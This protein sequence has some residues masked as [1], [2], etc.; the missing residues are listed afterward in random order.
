VKHLRF[1]ILP[2]LLWTSPALACNAEF[3]PNDPSAVTFNDPTVFL[4]ASSVYNVPQNVD[5][6]V[7]LSVWLRPVT[8]GTDGAFS[9]FSGEVDLVNPLL[10]SPAIAVLVFNDVIEINYFDTTAGISGPGG[11][12]FSDTGVPAD[13]NWHHL[14]IVFN[15]VSASGQYSIDGVIHD[16]HS[17]ATNGSLNTGSIKFWAAGASDNDYSG[18]MAEFYLNLNSGVSSLT[19]AVV[20]EFRDSFTGKAVGLGANCTGPTGSVPNMCDRGDPCTYIFGPRPNG[21][22]TYVLKETIKGSQPLPNGADTDPCLTDG[23]GQ[24]CAP[25]K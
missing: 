16:F 6:G 7:L 25:N 21:G 3:C 11:N 20:Q 14:A 9:P 15:P 2:L 8:Y 24:G 23:K 22:L 10:N 18:D 5:S 17:S 12:L 19:D 4:N 13:G 1:L